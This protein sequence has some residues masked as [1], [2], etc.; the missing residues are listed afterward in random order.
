MDN[1]GAQATVTIIHRTK[2]SDTNKQNMQYN[3]KS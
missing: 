2:I 1:T 3:T